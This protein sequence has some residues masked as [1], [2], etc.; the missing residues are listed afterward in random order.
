MLMTLK[1][2]WIG[3]LATRH[4][5]VL[6]FFVHITYEGLEPAAMLEIVDA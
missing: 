3:G 2:E 6:T 1:Q 4:Y 5:L